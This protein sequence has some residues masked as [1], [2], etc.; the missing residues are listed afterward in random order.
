M[1]SLHSFWLYFQE[2]ITAP[3]LPI[4]SLIIA[5]TGLHYSMLWWAVIFV[6]LS[7]VKDDASWVSGEIQNFRLVFMKGASTSW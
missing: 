1:G 7:A 3:H 4:F 6:L 5:V 2:R